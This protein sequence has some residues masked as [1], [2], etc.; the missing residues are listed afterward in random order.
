MRQAKNSPSA[1]TAAGPALTR[2]RVALCT[3]G[4]F[5]R[6]KQSAHNFLPSAGF[7][8]C[9]FQAPVLSSSRIKNRCFICGFTCLPVSL[10]FSY[11]RVFVI[12][13]LF[14]LGYANACIPKTILV[15]GFPPS[16]Y[17]TNL[18]PSSFTVH[19][20]KNPRSTRAQLERGKKVALGRNG[21]Q[22]HDLQTRLPREHEGRGP[23]LSAPVSAKE[24]QTTS[25]GLA[26]L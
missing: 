4:G 18:Y 10:A 25:K 17:D 5:S 19:P 1:L 22:H 26:D 23:N 11:L 2:S 15:V 20:S 16:A 24:L 13:S 14:A 9:L 21:K 3:L 12:P 7:F 6:P 8:C